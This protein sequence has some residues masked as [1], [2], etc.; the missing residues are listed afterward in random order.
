MFAVDFGTYYLD[1]KARVYE[2]EVEPYF[3]TQL[4]DFS[5]TLGE[6]MTV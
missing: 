1:I 5:I 4:D 3:S 2:K 6:S